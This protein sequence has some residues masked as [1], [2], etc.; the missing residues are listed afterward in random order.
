MHSTTSV[1]T[2]SGLLLLPL[3]LCIGCQPFDNASVISD[4]S[5]TN[6]SDETIKK[7]NTVDQP[8]DTNQHSYANDSHLSRSAVAVQP[9]EIDGVNV[10]LL[11]VKRS[12]DKTLTA[13]W[14]YTNTTD[15]EKVLIK[16]KGYRDSRSSWIAQAYLIDNIN[17]KKHPVVRANP[18]NDPI[19]RKTTTN[20]IVLQPGKSYDVW[21][22]FPSPPESVK[23][24]SVYIP[25]TA[26]IEGVSITD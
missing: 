23:K 10:E 6:A 11:S 14:R 8:A 17:Q 19:T 12:S 2:R 21:A 25:A 1:L 9:H 3:A 18:G 7:S 20:T 24:I 13:Y 4:S 5:V 26:P 15:E 22:K 16:N